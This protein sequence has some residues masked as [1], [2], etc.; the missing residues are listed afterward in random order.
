[1]GYKACLMAIIVCMAGLSAHAEDRDDWKSFQVVKDGK[2]LYGFKNAQ[3]E[4][5][6]EPKYLWADD[7]SEELAAVQDVKTKKFG[8]INQKGKVIIRFMYDE[9]YS[10]GRY[11]QGKGGFPQLALVNIGNTEE[12]RFKLFTQGKWGLIDKKGRVVLPIK[13]GHIF[14]L[15][16]GMACIFDGI[17]AI[18]KKAS[19][20]VQGKYGFINDTGVIMIVP[21]YDKVD[22]AFVNG[23]IKVNKDGE[24]FKINKKG[25]RIDQIPLEDNDIITFNLLE[26]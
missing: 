22:P 9:A 4:V 2:A 11:K 13:Y 10:F 19:V 8:F 23:V 24:E 21:I 14:P 12:Y 6:I 1:M 3:G 26:L 16:E 18:D 25:E 15:K 20:D 5:M 17:F 7:F